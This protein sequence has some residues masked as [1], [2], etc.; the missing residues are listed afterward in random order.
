MKMPPWTSVI[1]GR[2]QDAD[3]DARAA[4]RSQASEMAA[5]LQRG[6]ADSYAWWWVRADQL[7]LAD[8][9]TIERI[10]IVAGE[11]ASADERLG[12]IHRAAGRRQATDEVLALAMRHIH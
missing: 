5:A 2:A 4:E 12:L 8:R 10:A 9:A 3:R 1:K 7:T 11:I 6:M